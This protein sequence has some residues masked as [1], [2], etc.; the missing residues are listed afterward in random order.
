MVGEVKVD[1]AVTK[2]EWS[3]LPP[4]NASAVYWDVIVKYEH[5]GRLHSFATS[6]TDDDPPELVSDKEEPALPP[7]PSCVGH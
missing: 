7:P 6:H 5:A 2:E 4:F 1:D 3:R